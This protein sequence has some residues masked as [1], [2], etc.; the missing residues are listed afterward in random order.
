MERTL[1]L[2]ANIVNEGRIIEGDVLIEGDRIAQ[3]GGDQSSKSADKTIDANGKYLMPG[4]ID[5][6]VHFRESPD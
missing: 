5:D 6:Q 1:I 2:N 3:V 4:L